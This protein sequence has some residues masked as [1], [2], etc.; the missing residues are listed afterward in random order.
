MNT[1]QKH[2]FN[3]RSE[4]KANQPF[5]GKK[6]ED[7]PKEPGTPIPEEPSVPKPP[8]ENPNPTSPEPGINEPEKDDPTRI[9]EEPPIFNNY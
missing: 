7:P 6:S 5:S 2:Q 1:N 9:D 4:K 8:D 3:Q